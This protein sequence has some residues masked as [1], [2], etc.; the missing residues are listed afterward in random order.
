[1]MCLCFYYYGVTDQL[2]LLHLLFII[3][4]QIGGMYCLLYSIYFDKV[5]GFKCRV[6]VFLVD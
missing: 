1:M 5:V 2:V 6:L 4:G 3:K